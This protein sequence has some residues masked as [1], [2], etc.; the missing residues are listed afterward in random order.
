MHPPT[1]H[2]SRMPTTFIPHT[3]T[4]T[5]SKRHNLGAR[6]WLSKGMVISRRK[7]SNVD[8][9]KHIHS[10]RALFSLPEHTPH[11]WGFDPVVVVVAHLCQ[12]T[13]HV[14]AAYAVDSHFDETLAIDG[15]TSPLA[16]NV[17]RVADILQSSLVDSRE[18]ADSAP[19]FTTALRVSRRGDK[20]I[21]PQ[22]PYTCSQYTHTHT[23][24]SLDL[25][26]AGLLHDF[27]VSNEEHL[28]GQLLLQ[29]RAHSVVH[30]L[31]R[32]ELLPGDKHN[33][34]GAADLRHLNLRIITGPLPHNE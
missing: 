20:T 33:H 10:I 3:H 26:A 19:K 23:P 17:I 14:G 31:P 24:W 2:H 28:L 21:P 25:L 32:L 11:R 34:H 6:K 1:Q 18:G 16:N 27:P 12:N 29:V 30:T 22:P 15:H 8:K 4:H 9:V 13:K 7:S 5:H